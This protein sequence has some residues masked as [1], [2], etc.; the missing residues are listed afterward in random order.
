ME[1]EKAQIE[2]FKK[3][4]A[5]KIPEN[6][7]YNSVKGISNIARDGLNEVRPISI[8]EATRISGVSGHDIALLIG[9]ISK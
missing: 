2:K 7:D 5:M 8:G 9:S 4:E 1:R 6:F 3:L